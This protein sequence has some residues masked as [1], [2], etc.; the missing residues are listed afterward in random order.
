MRMTYLGNGM[1]W[2]LDWDWC[3]C[4]SASDELD[5]Y[6]WMSLLKFEML[7]VF[8][9]YLGE[10]EDARPPCTLFESIWLLPNECTFD[11]KFTIDLFELVSWVV[12][13]EAANVDVF[14]VD[15]SLS[16]ALERADN[17]G[18]WYF[19]SHVLPKTSS[20]CVELK[21]FWMPSIFITS[22]FVVGT[23]SLPLPNE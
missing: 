16:L 3:W 12:S 9:L 10:T 21:F 22:R 7:S 23:L 19:V 2:P 17:F 20:D 14:V 11:M 8:K 18:I 4:W 15:V 6:M 13:G 5:L 1:W